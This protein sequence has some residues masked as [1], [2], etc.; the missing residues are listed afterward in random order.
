MYID[1]T[2]YTHTQTDTVLVLAGPVRSDLLMQIT[3]VRIILAFLTPQ[4]PGLTRPGRYE[5]RQ[6]KVWT[7]TVD[8][9][10]EQ[11]SYSPPI[12]LHP[13][14]R[15]FFIGRHD[16]SPLELCE[17]FLL[18]RHLPLLFVPLTQMTLSAPN[19]HPQT[20]YRYHPSTHSSSASGW[21]ATVETAPSLLWQASC[22][23]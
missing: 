17:L 7:V 22:L 14:Q 4:I 12:K 21:D 20:E 18:H 16:P 15:L 3:S 8:S 19:L 6:K 5:K 10:H 9:G 23:R 1:G 2:D 11:A 13:S